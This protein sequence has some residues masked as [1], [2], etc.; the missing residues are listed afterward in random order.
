MIRFNTNYPQV[1]GKF[2]PEQI[3]HMSTWAKVPDSQVV[4]AAMT[5]ISCIPK[6]ASTETFVNPLD[7]AIPLM[8]KNDDRGWC[9]TDGD[10]WG[11]VV[12]AG[13]R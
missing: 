5:N 10:D 11:N 12:A 13:R 8:G 7:P 6:G 4:A 1:A 3:A 2:K 9:Y